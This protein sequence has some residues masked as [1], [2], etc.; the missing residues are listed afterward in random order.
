MFS[1][2]PNTKNVLELYSNSVNSFK[3]VQ[4]VSKRRKNIKPHMTK[5]VHNLHFKYIKMWPELVMVKA[6]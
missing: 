2:I 4:K 1:K 5:M 6:H 3:Y